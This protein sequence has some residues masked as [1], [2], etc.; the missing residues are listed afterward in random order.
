MVMKAGSDNFRA[1]SVHGIMERIN[2]ELL[3]VQMA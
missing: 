3:Q 1:S 2:S